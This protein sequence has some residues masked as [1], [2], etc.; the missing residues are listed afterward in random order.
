[1]EKSIYWDIN[2]SWSLNKLF[3]FIV[4]NRS[5]GKTF[6]CKEKA[7]NNFKKT[8]KKF[9]YVK[10]YK[11]DLKDISNFFDDIKAFFPDDELEVKGKHFYINKEICGQWLP[12]V[13][14]KSYKSTPFPDYNLIIFDEFILEKGYIHYL[15]N[16]VEQFLELYSTIARLRNDVRVYFLA[17]AIS[18]YNPYFL[19]FDL[20][21][22]YGKN[23]YIKDDIFVEF[24]QKEEFINVAKQTRFGKLISG[25]TYGAYAIENKFLLDNKNFIEKK[26]GLCNYAFTF[27]YNK[28]YYGVWFSYEQGKIWISTDILKE[29]QVYAITKN[30]LQPNTMLL[31]NFK[32]NVQFKWFMSNYAMGNVYSENQKIKKA[33]EEII[34]TVKS[35]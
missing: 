23:R 11:P 18:V 20:N 17:N 16:E 31:L 4:G 32:N 12:L 6:G 13:K 8:G 26:T 9:I 25:T 22:P 15:P 2:P 33:I 28:N 30:D 5:C 21:I 10:R 19:Y 1:M 27:L 3:S 24:E 14:Q 34:K 7:L 29:K 35:F